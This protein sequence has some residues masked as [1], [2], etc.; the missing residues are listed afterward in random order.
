[1]K[2][3]KEIWY[4]LTAT[5]ISDVELI[6]ELWCEIN[7]NYSNK[8]REYHNLSHLAYMIE[9]AFE[10]KSKIVDFDTL[11]FSIFYHDIIYNSKRSDNELESAKIA[12]NRLKR[13]G[14]LNDRVDKCYEQI[15]ATKNH[16]YNTESDTN[17]LLDFD[18]AILGDEPQKYL[19]YTKKIRKEYSIYPDFLYNMGRKK[20]LKHF[21]E[22][23]KIFK[24]SE[25][26]TNFEQQARKNLITELE[27]K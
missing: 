14:F 13:L 1:M 10:Y 26:K 9:L 12:S 24:T 2:N 17:F 11:L 8:N 6:D 25:F 23:D 20:V 7:I 16:Q 4:D 15:L 5:Y 27:N 21:L 19:D 3:L 18:L 22:M